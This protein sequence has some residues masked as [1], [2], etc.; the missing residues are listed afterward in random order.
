[1]IKEKHVN[2]ASIRHNSSRSIYLIFGALYS[3]HT[4]TLYILLN[5][6]CTPKLSAE[7]AILKS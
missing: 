3:A 6:Q 2:I 1:M 7:C 5:A 4:R